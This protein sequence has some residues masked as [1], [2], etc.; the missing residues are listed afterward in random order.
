MVKRSREGLW[1]RVPLKRGKMRWLRRGGK[2]ISNSVY[3][4]SL[5]IFS[6]ITE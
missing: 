3:K 6:N 5:D 1:K 4:N 2:S